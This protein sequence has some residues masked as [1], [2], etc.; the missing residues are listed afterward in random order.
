LT[1]TPDCASIYGADY[2]EHSCGVPYRRDEHWLGFFGGIADRIVTDIRPGTVLDA[3][4]AMGFLVEALRDRGVEAF[5]VDISEYAIEQVRED[6]REYCRV[7]SVTEPFADRFDLIVCFE[8]LEHLEPRDAETAVANIC[9]HTDDCLFSSTPLDFI[10]PTHVNVQPPEYWTELFARHGL[11]RDV[12]FNATFVVPWAR[13]YRRLE[14]PVPRLLAGYERRLWRLEHSDGETQ[15]ERARV[16]AELEHATTHL[17]NARDE[18]ERLHAALAK[19]E[20]AVAALTDEV[21]REQAARAA[22]RSAAEAAEAA[23]VEAE[24]AAARA[25]AELAAV[26]QT[27]LWRWTAG[28]RSVYGRLR[29]IVQK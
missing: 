13:R 24:H 14:E 5:G 26:Y 8:V 1:G 15:H 2:F 22:E 4:C 9:A 28:A 3:G 7:G 29:T 23:R 18:I 19:R 6:I 11:Y 12:D 10:E 20:T 25:H 17:A 16:R 21:E 27:R